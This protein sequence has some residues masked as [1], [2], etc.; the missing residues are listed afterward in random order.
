MRK[1]SIALATLALQH[2]KLF[3]PG[4]CSGVEQPMQGPIAQIGAG[5]G[6]FLDAEG[7]LLAA[8]I[9]PTPCAG[10]L[11]RPATRCPCGSHLGGRGEAGEGEVLVEGMRMC[12]R[13]RGR[14][15]RSGAL[16]AGR[17]AG[18]ISGQAL[19]SFRA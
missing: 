16:E 17:P 14:R 10:P 6:S 2:E 19:F 4:D 11:P 5:F 12:L 3:P 18:D 7:R 15:R 1:L 8:A 13:A 9:W